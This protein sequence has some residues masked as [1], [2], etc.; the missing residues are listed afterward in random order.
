FARANIL[1]HDFSLASQTQEL[2]YEG[3][4]FVMFKLIARSMVLLFVTALTALM[5][6]DSI[7]QPVAASNPAA[8]PNPLLGEWAGPYGGVPPF[9]KVQI[10]LFKPALE[11]AMAENLKE[12][13]NIT[14][15]RSAPTFEDT[16][17]TLEKAGH[18]FDRV[19]TVY[20]IWSSTMSNAEFQ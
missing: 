9:D 12:I 1:S 7:K 5:A 17:V 10:A 14:R 19:A 4:C 6:T 3:R 18:T 13:D 16:I 8:D 20:G 2:H 11:A 15:V